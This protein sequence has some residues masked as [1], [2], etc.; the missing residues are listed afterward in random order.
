MTGERGR[1]P[2][3]KRS[4]CLLC[5]VLLVV[6]AASAGEPQSVPKADDTLTLV[7]G[8]RLSGRLQ[9]IEANGQ[10]AFEV[11]GTTRTL[12]LE[13]CEMLTRGSVTLPARSATPNRIWLRSGALLEA[14]VT[15]GQAASG[16]GSDVALALAFAPREVRMSM[17]HLRAFRL[18]AETDQDGGFA[19]ALDKPLADKDLLFVLQTGQKPQRLSVLCKGITDKELV[20][21][22]SGQ[23]RK[24]ALDRIYGVVF[25]KNSGTPPAVQPMPRTILEIGDGSRFEGKL[26]ALTA[27]GTA[28]LRLDEGIELEFPV[29][30]VA[31]LRVRSDKLVYLSDLQPLKVEQTPAFDRVWPWLRDAAPGGSPILLHGKEFARG[32]VLIPRTRLTF[33]IGGRFDAFRATI[34]IDDRAGPRAHAV[35]RIVGDDKVLAEYPAIT[36]TSEP[37]AIDVPVGGVRRLV[38]EADFG[39][40][41][42]LG[43][44][45]AFAAARL[46][47]S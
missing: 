3:A 26:V 45:C 24:V 35:F 2:F 17:R 23:D 9:A 39:A 12:P 27:Q 46:V 22:F 28:T 30:F 15:G 29:G 10:V 6:L 13:L 47:K 16:E 36:H 33:D 25:G 14:A 18:G 40:N 31:A 7:S 43:D 34:G 42:D 11:G 19:Q 8:E 4:A 38:I 41:F 32:I 20:I 37:V 1:T 5:A 44:H 21:E